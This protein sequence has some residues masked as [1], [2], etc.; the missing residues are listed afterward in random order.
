MVIL[1]IEEELDDLTLVGLSLENG[2]LSTRVDQ[3]EFTIHSTSC[4]VTC[5]WTVVHDVD[6]TFVFSLAGI[7]LP[8][9]MKLHCVEYGQ[10]PL[11]CRHHETTLGIILD[12]CND[13][14]EIGIINFIALLGTHFDL[15]SL[16]EQSVDEFLSLVLFLFDS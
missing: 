13:S 1:I 11:E 15:F 8:H 3:D 16:S 12:S 2:S 5:S 4:N 9:F 7:A 14:I 6:R 10:E